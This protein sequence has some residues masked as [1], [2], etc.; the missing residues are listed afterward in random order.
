M[1]GY[2]MPLFLCASTTLSSTHTHFSSFSSQDLARVL[3]TRSREMI[4]LGPFGLSTIPPP[5]SWVMENAWLKPRI[6]QQECG[7]LKLCSR[8][9]ELQETVQYHAQ[10]AALCRQLHSNYLVE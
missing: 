1:I 8:W 5:C 10:L 7:D 6:S 3:L 4:P 2:W 9:Q